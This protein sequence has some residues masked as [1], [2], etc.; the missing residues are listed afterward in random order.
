MKKLYIIDYVHN[1][2]DVEQYGEAT[3]DLEEA[4]KTFKEG[5]HAFHL[6][7]YWKGT[8]YIAETDDSE[9]LILRTIEI[10]EEA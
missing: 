7:D 6:D 4:K 9:A 3:F 2:G 1:Y 5:V 8:A 10:P